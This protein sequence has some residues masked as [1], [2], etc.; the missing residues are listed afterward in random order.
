MPFIAF[1][2]PDIANK[3]LCRSREFAKNAANVGN[4]GLPRLYLRDGTGSLKS[5]T[6]PRYARIKISSWPIKKTPCLN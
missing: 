1:D 2:P 4:V 5:L 3:S 6:R